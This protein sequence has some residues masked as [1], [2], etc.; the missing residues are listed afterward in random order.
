MY[1]KDNDFVTNILNKIEQGEQLT[2]REKQNIEI[3]LRLQVCYDDVLNSVLNLDNKINFIY[4]H[5]I[6]KDVCR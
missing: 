4:K 3:G 6:K 1:Q 5:P 2:Y